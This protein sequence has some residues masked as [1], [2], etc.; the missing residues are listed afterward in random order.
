MEDVLMKTEMYGRNTTSLDSVVPL[1]VTN[2]CVHL[3]FAQTRMSGHYTERVHVG[4]GA[5]RSR[6]RVTNRKH[7]GLY[8]CIV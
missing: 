1:S 3:M 2:K 5:L 6:S 7:L 8:P 4:V